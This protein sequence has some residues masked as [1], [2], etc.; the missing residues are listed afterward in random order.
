M[1][2]GGRRA[3]NCFLKIVTR[4][5]LLTYKYWGCIRVAWIYEKMFLLSAFVSAV[6]ATHANAAAASFAGSTS[7]FQFPPADVAATASLVDTYFPDASQVGFPGVTPSKLSLLSQLV[8][9]STFGLAG[10]EAQSVATAPAVP[11]VASY[12]PLIRPETSD[13]KGIEYNVIDSWANLSP[14]QSVSSFGLD[15][16]S[17][18]IPEG[19]KINQVFLLHRHG[20]RYPTSTAPPPTFAAAVHAAASNGTFTATGPLSFLK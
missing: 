17:E 13:K 10:D 14:M 18:H 19:C 15:G 6:L 5:H 3:R 7:T 4:S 1:D 16:A 12:F 9:F 2:S 11:K 8:K 20:A